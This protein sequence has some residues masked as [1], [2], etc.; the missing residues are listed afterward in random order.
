MTGQAEAGAISGYATRRLDIDTLGKLECHDITDEIKEFARSCAAP[1]GMLLVQSLH[2]TAGLLINE[3]ETGFRKDLAG[4]A[5]GL[6]SCEDEYVHDDMSVR[7]ENICP[8][9]AEW[10][11]GHSH[12]QGALFGTSTLMLPAMAGEVVLGRWQRVLLLEFDRARPR[13]VVLHMFGMAA[14]REQGPPRLNGHA[15]AGAAGV[16]GEPAGQEVA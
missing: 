6:V 9:D 12:V 3:W 2:T 16:N 8:E 13:T 11:N 1:A 15:M 4:A 10:P 5:E 7:W 14:M